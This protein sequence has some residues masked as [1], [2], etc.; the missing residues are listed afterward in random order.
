MFAIAT[1]FLENT[2]FKRVS[3]VSDLLTNNVVYV[4]PQCENLLQALFIYRYALLPMIK[5]HNVDHVSLCIK[6]L[7]THDKRTH[8]Q[9]SVDNKDDVCP[10]SLNSTAFGGYRS[11]DSH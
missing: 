3:I 6:R 7:E 11:I 1:R 2:E 9:L 5:E 8:A 10:F 4:Y